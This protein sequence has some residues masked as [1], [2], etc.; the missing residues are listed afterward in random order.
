MNAIATKDITDEQVVRAAAAFRDD[1]GPV[2]V[3]VRTVDGLMSA[4]GAPYK[5]ALRA[6]ERACRRGLVDW[7]V[8]PDVAWPTPAGDAMMASPQ[9]LVLR[10]PSDAE[11]ADFKRAFAVQFGASYLLDVAAG[12][13]DS[14]LTPEHARELAV[15]A[16]AVDGAP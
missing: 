1:H 4:T 14:T 11:L 5:V 12:E 10:E 6:I 16:L 7:G 2:G 8:C 3:R 15:Q 9:P 13:G